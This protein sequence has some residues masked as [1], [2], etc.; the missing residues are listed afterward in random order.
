MVEHV[1]LRLRFRLM[2]ELQNFDSIY[3][4]EEFVRSCHARVEDEI[5]FPALRELLVAERRQEQ[6]KNVL[7]R[8]EADHRM[9]DTIGDQIKLRTIQG[10]AP[11]LSKRISLYCTTVETHNTTEE[12]QL[13]PQW[14]ASME[15]E[16]E[17]RVKALEIIRQFGLNRYYEL[18]G[19]SEQLL[20]LTFT[21]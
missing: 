4:I 1:S 14:K 9:I 2:R 19:I 11:T 3:G 21:F 8:L 13:F 20:R 6:V 12:V 15:Q 18:T 17:F 16:E 5:V 7:S 10:D